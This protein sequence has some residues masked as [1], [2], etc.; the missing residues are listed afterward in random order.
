MH[1]HFENVRLPDQIFSHM[2]ICVHCFKLVETGV[3]NLD[4]HLQ[5]CEPYQEKIVINTDPEH[6]RKAMIKFMKTGEF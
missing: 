4:R 3:M 2:V 5:Q 1:E 6:I